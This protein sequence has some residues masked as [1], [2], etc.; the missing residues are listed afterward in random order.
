MFDKIWNVTQ[1]RFAE[2]EKELNR[3]S[4]HGWRVEYIFPE[5]TMNSYRIVA[6]KGG[7][8]LIKH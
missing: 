4:Y 3:L 6:S 5:L 7:D 1:V 2:L 8:I